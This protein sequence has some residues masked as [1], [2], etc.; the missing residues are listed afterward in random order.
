MLF[1]SKT[2]LT[3]FQ[4]LKGTGSTVNTCLKA[5]KKQT[6]SSIQIQ[7]IFKKQS[8]KIQKKSVSQY[9]PVDLK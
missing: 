7:H 4:L 2:K 3:F 6:F 5:Q 1:F 8:Q 9:L